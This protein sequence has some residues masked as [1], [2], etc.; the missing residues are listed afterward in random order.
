MLLPEYGR[1]VD[2][3]TRLHI[4]LHRCQGFILLSGCLC[5][6]NCELLARESDAI[7]K[8]DCI[9]LNKTSVKRRPMTRARAMGCRVHVQNLECQGCALALPVQGCGVF[10]RLSCMY[11][12]HCV[13][14][15]SVHD[16]TI[17][18]AMTGHACNNL[19]SKLCG[20]PAYF[21]V[22]TPPMP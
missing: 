16:W 10:H 19:L 18:A 15:Q 8:D 7:S 17:Q 20:G 6:H 14:L 21:L 12:S 1:R 4:Y 22:V 2:L 9:N 5:P 13:K 3:F 11:N